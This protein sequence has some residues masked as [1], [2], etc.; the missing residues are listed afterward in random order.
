MLINLQV[1]GAGSMLS[2]LTSSLAHFKHVPETKYCNIIPLPNRCMRFLDDGLVDNFLKGKI[3]V[4]MGRVPAEFFADNKNIAGFDNPGKCL[5]TTMRELV[6]NA[7]DSA[8]IIEI[9]IEEIVRNKF[10]SMIGL[11]DH[12]CRD[13]ALYED[14]A[15]AKSK[16]VALGKKVKDPAAAKATKGREASYYR[17]ACMDNGRGMPH[18]DILIM[19]GR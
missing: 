16:N 10:N 15:T 3:I 5:Y 17:V 9:T 13:E 8:D 11:A 6:E 7:L 19:F 14:F 1:M 2:F 4:F 12:E 18:D